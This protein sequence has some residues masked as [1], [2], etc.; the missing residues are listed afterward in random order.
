[1]IDQNLLE[2]RNLKKHFSDIALNSFNGTKFSVVKVVDGVSFNIRYGETLG[3]VGETGSG[4]STVGRAVLR[5]IEPTSGEVLFKGKNLLELPSEEL[6]NIRKEMQMVFQDPYGSLNPKMTVQRIL[7]EPFRIH[8][9]LDTRGF[10]DSALE[11]LAKVGL[12]PEYGERYPHEFS[13]GQRQRIGIARAIALNPDLI[14]ADEPV[15]AL[16]VS[17]QAQIIN[18]LQDLKESLGISYLFISHDMEVVEHFCDRVAVMYFGKI[19]ELASSEDV[20]QRTSHP[21]TKALLSAV[22]NLEGRLP[23]AMVGGDIPN[24]A[25]FSSG[26]SF[27]S[28]C[29]IK[30]KACDESDPPLKEVAPDHFAACHL[31]G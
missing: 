11:T 21:Y 5:L 9:L 10:K 15:S 6:R 8:Q 31:I 3:L 2:V 4:K 20:Y 23:Q 26:C 13:G 17:I 19:V 7:E 16:D 28:R 29:P 14:I 22:P 30:E 1:M 12:S 18:L 24:P 25:N 27:S